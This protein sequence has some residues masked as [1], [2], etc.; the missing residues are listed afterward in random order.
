M[1][2]GKFSLTLIHT[3]EN[4]AED[5]YSIV[6]HVLAQRHISNGMSLAQKHLVLDIIKE[7]GSLEY[8]VTALR[9]IGQKI[10]CEIRRIENV[11]GIENKPLR[12]LFEV[13]KI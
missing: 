2:E 7:T 8:T 3:L 5:S 1:D 11:T 4:A 12:G 6:K 10:D 13:L 9:E